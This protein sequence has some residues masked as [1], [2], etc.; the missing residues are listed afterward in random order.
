MLWVQ[1]IVLFS[2]QQAGVGCWAPADAVNASVVSLKGFGRPHVALASRYYVNFAVSA[3]SSQPETV[4]PR[5]PLKRVDGCVSL[6]LEDFLP[7]VD[8]G[9]LPYFDESI[10]PTG[11]QDILVLGMRPGQLP[12]RPLVSLERR[13]ALRNNL[14]SVHFADFDYAIA[15]ASGNSVSREVKLRIIL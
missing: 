5:C 8:F 6:D 11:C 10:I 9:L 7:L 3:A 1:I 14:F 12:T 2:H 4:L 15:I 13:N